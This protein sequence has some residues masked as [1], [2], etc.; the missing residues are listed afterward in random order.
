MAQSPA[1]SPAPSAS[2]SSS[3]DR[4]DPPVI[5]K[6][7]H[8]EIEEDEEE[9]SAVES[10]PEEAD[11]ED[12]NGNNKTV[13]DEELPENKDEADAASER[14]SHSSSGAS[15]SSVSG[16]S[17]EGNAGV[18]SCEVT[19]C[20]DDKSPTASP[21][22]AAIIVVTPSSWKCTDNWLA[23]TILIRSHRH[24]DSFQWADHES[25]ANLSLF[26]LLPFSARFSST[27][28]SSSK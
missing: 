27:F 19:I 6:A 15:N 14:S 5:K 24:L 9:E 1:H 2:G 16:P 4:D 18:L 21:S 20:T 13:A 17:N 11:E 8:L 28:P 7:R 23:M 12:D 22:S 3:S 10:S 25:P 26:F